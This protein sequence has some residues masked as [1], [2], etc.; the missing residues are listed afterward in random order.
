P[1][2][3]EWA[4]STSVADLT[5]Q[6]MQQICSAFQSNG[7]AIA[8]MADVY[9][10]AHSSFLHAKPSGLLVWVV[11]FSFVTLINMCAVVGIGV[12]RYLS[13]SVYNQVIT[14]MVGLGVGSLSGSSLYHLLPQAY[15][16]LLQQ[17]DEHGKP[18]HAY[19]NMAHFSIIGIYTF[20]LADKLIKIILQ[21]RKG[22]RSVADP[23]RRAIG[24]GEGGE[25]HGALLHHNH[26]HKGEGDCAGDVELNAA[27]A[28]SC[29]SMGDQ[30]HGM[31]SHEH[32]LEFHAG[33]SPIAA[34]AWMILFGDGLHN[35]ID[36]ISI[37]A[38][39][40]ESMHSGLSVSLAVLAE[41]FPHEL[42][43]V[44]ILVASGLTLRQ[45]LM[46]NLFSALT[47]Y[48]GFGIG[49][50]VGEGGPDNT[51]YLF[52]LAA[53][54]FLYIS[55]SCMMPEMKKAMEEALAVSITKG[56]YVFFLQSAGLFTGLFLMYAM[57]R[58]GGEIEI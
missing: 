35:L 18:S 44:A 57:A 27:E 1:N 9:P 16:Q 2:I 7:T 23:A 22:G 32:Q 51:T 24:N 49:V 53:G 21:W 20:F 50:L 31:C 48:V 36:G 28:S 52:A 11:G 39:F 37:G 15:P 33:D 8:P 13:K 5:D 41:E 26:H 55:L 40:A 19:L 42:G 56:L 6:Q 46:Y 12:M 4:P 30:A 17:V 34:V 43:D 3:F 14:Y 58:W 45:A 25:S 10:S 29:K 54:M 47:C 38:S